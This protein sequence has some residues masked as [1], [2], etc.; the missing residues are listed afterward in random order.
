MR[1]RL[2]LLRLILGYFKWFVFVAIPVDVVVD[3]FA[4]FLEPL[5][6]GV[7]G[8]FQFHYYCFG[9]FQVDDHHTHAVSV[10]VR[11][12]EGRFAIGFTIGANA[13]EGVPTGTERALDYV[14]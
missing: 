12:N 3:F 13:N 1:P 2:H 10:G 4:W 14:S 5:F 7:F 6:D 8:E 9:G 11:V